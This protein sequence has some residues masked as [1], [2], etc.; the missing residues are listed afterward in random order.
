MPETAS[1]VTVYVAD[2]EKNGSDIW[3]PVSWQNYKGY[4]RQK[5]FVCTE[6]ARKNAS[7][8]ASS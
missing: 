7:L 5:I 3:F 6:L 2:W 1:D 4:L 8:S